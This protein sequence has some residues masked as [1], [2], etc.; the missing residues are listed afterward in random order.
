MTTGWQ[1]ISDH[2][3]YLGSDGKM[4]DGWKSIGGQWYFF[5]T[6]KDVPAHATIKGPHGSMLAGGNFTIGSK[7]YNFNSSGHCTNPY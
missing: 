6:A 3:F 2:W 4:V 1:K 5:R 7:T